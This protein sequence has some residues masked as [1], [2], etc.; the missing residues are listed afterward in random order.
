[1][2]D[3]VRPREDEDL[4]G[5][6]DPNRGWFGESWGAPICAPEGHRETPVGLECGRCGVPIAA[7]SQGI[8]TPLVGG[9][10]SEPT[11]DGE[12]LVYVTRLA[13]HLDCWLESILPHG[14]D[15]PGC[16]GKKRG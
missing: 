8:L 6:R 5:V 11:P 13:W 9:L 7:D 1:M 16:R 10:A 12:A 2:T 15:C 4:Q 14:P 3:D